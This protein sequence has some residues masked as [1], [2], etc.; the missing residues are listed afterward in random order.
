[1]CPIE[2]ENSVVI[3]ERPDLSDPLRLA[4]AYGD[5]VEDIKTCNAR[6]Q[7]LN[8]KVDAFNKKD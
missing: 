4:S 6:L 8:D 3:E 2:K 5:R 1:M 7:G